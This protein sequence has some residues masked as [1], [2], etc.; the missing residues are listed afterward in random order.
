MKRWIFFT[1]LALIAAPGL[2][3]A[4]PS[5]NWDGRPCQW[6]AA[7]FEV[8]STERSDIIP[9]YVSK[10]A[11]Y[12]PNPVE[13]ALIDI[14]Q[15]AKAALSAPPDQRNDVLSRV[16][17]AG[18]DLKDAVEDYPNF[19]KD[20]SDAIKPVAKD[21]KRLGER[22]MIYAGDGS[23]ENWENIVSVLKDLELKAAVWS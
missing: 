10:R 17:S 23:E 22:M 11:S 5:V 14:C 13:L 1:A 18:I 21:I 12:A 6:G 15:R 7:S 20:N 16:V 3:H 4:A 19:A 8:C 2:A 9:C